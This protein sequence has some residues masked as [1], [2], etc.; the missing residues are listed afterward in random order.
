MTS[1]PALRLHNASLL[2][3][4]KI[5]HRARREFLCFKKILF[6]FVPN[7]LGMLNI[8]SLCPLWLPFASQKKSHGPA[9]MAFRIINGSE[10]SH[11]I[12]KA[13]GEPIFFSTAFLDRLLLFGIPF[14]SIATKNYFLFYTSPAWCQ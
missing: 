9:P 3:F 13:L 7:D 1:C 10:G 11:D 14:L 5:N 12:P 4:K 6:F 8:S 2:G